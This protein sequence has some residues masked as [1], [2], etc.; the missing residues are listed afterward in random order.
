MAL[1]K[2]SV[3]PAKLV[4]S[5]V[6]GAT[7]PC[8]SG[9][10]QQAALA[11]RS[12]CVISLYR[13]SDCHVCGAQRNLNF[14]HHETVRRWWWW[15]EGEGGCMSRTASLN[16]I[17]FGRRNVLMPWLTPELSQSGHQNVPPAAAEQHF[18]QTQEINRNKE[19]NIIFECGWRTL[20]QGLRSWYLFYTEI[21]WWEWRAAGG[22]C[23][24]CFGFCMFTTITCFLWTKSWSICRSFHLSWVQISKAKWAVWKS[25][26]SGRAW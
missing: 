16:P 7:A 13:E 14:S 21:G 25:P 8:N 1:I 22:C 5:T 20:H 18:L 26:S 15:E 12:F 4:A 9:D 11:R 3:E 24:C 17:M 6:G 19:Q 2:F 23:V 10:D